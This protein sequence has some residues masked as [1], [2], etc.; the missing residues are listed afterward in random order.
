[1]AVIFQRMAK[2]HMEKHLPV[3]TADLKAQGKWEEYTESLALEAIQELYNQVVIG[4]AQ[5]AATREMVIQ[6]I[7]LL[8]PE[9]PE[10]IR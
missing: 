4:K 9:N 8:P 2:R 10:T 1:M 7:L 3:L 6:E 5:H